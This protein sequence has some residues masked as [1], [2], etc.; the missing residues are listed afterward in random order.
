MTDLHLNTISST[1][2]E[3]MVGFGKSDLSQKFYLAGG[4]ALALQLGHRQS[5]DLDFFTQTEDIPSSKQHIETSLKSYNPV[6]TDSS[7]GNLIFLINSI[8]V[9]F[10][11]YGYPLVAP[12]V[13]IHG[14]HLAGLADIGLMKM[15]TLLGRASRKDFHDLYAIC[16]TIPIQDLLILAPQKYPG[17][18]D[19]EA[20]IARHLAYYERADSE[21][22]VPLLQ[23]VSWEE[24]KEFFINW[25]K[26]FPNPG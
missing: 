24:V 12:L 10:F 11:A 19:F 3:I 13:E 1:M 25:V 18:R 5:I 22:P 9:G 23:E 2:K 16:Q 14:I 7:W 20:Q 15:D 21:A 17:I 4:T 6:L 26:T 8:R